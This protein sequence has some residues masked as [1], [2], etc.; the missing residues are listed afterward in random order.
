MEPIPVFFDVVD[1][2]AL[3]LKPKKPFLDW[4][5]SHDPKDKD[6]DLAEDLDVYLIP[7]FY[8]PEDFDVW[9][10]TNF[11]VFFCDQMNHWYTDEKMW[12]QDRTFKLFK[13]WF[14][15]KMHSMVWDTL[16]EPIE[17]E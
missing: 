8:N 3:I 5:I 13:E 2:A 17:K 16:E 15:Y 11:D 14:N 9:L 6:V 4:L 10:K 1:R 12:A 7:E